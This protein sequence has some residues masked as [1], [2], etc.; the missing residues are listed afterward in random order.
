VITTL[1]IILSDH[2]QSKLTTLGAGS[3]DAGASVALHR[4]VK[5]LNGRTRANP[6]D[7]AELMQVLR[8]NPNLS[9]SSLATTCAWISPSGL[10][11][12]YKAQRVVD[13][14]IAKGIVKRSRTTKKLTITKP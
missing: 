4:Y 8:L 1:S 5:M 2:E 9:L 10:P 11:L 6:N 14:L 3:L 7:E 12:K 13:R